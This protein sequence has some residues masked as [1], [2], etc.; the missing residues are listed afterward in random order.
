ML[1][2]FD[3]RHKR[4]NEISDLLHG[5]TKLS[6]KKRKDLGEQWYT[7][8]ELDIREDAKLGE[9]RERTLE[10]LNKETPEVEA[11]VTEEAEGE[12]PVVK[13]EVTE[14]VIV[15][16]KKD[17][18]TSLQEKRNEGYRDIH[19]V[20]MLKDEGFPVRAIKKAMEH[21]VDAFTTLPTSFG[22]IKGGLKEGVKLYDKVLKYIN[23]QSKKVSL[24]EA[25]SNAVEYLKK[26][27]AFKNESDIQQKQM[28]VDITNSLEN[29]FNKEIQDE[30]N[31]LKT[32]IKDQ[33]AGEKTLQKV[34]VDVK[35]FISK[36]MP[37]AEYSKSEVN[38]MLT[39]L[40]NANEKNIIVV[41]KK[42][43][44]L[45]LKKNIDITYGDIEAMLKDG[46]YTSKVSG[47]SKGKGIDSEYF[48]RLQDIKSNM[49]T[50]EDTPDQINEKR[51]KLL[52]K[53]NNKLNQTELTDKDMNE[54]VDIETALFYNEAMLMDDTNVHKFNNLE[55]VRDNLKQLINE[56]KIKR[57]LEL[58]KAHEYYKSLVKTAYEDI[59]GKEL[60]ETKEEKAA[61][62]DESRAFK[63]KQKAKMNRRIGG[64]FRKI[65]AGWKWY[66][67]RQE[68]L[69]G[70]IDT[71]SKSTGE[72]FGGKLQELTTDKI[73]DSNREYKRAV[74]GK[75]WIT[76]EL[77]EKQKEIYGKK[78]K[79]KKQIYRQQ[80]NTGVK[81]ST[82]EDI[83]LSQ[84]QAY[85]LYNQ[86]KD[87]ANHP[88]FETKWGEDHKRIMDEITEKFLKPEVKAWADWQ[89]D[90]FFPSVYERYNEVYKKIYRTNMPWNKFYAGFLSR[91][92]EVK[93]DI[94]LLEEQQKYQTSVGGQSTKLRVKNN[95]AINEE[96]GND[97]LFSY[98]QDM[99][100]FR[101]YAENVRDINKIFQN[102]DV[103]EAIEQTSGKDILTVLDK[104]LEN[105]ANRGLNKSQSAR[106]LNTLMNPFVTSR[107]GLN[108]TVAIKQTTSV[109]AFSSDIGIETWLKYGVN[110]TSEVM[111]GTWK[112]IYDN[113]PYIQDR[114]NRD[115]RDALEAYSGETLFSRTNKINDARI[116]FLD[117]LMYMIKQGDK[118]GIMGGMP[119][120][121]YYKDQY[122]KKNPN[123]TEKQVID[124]AIKR[125]EKDTKNAQQSSDIQ[126]RDTWQQNEHLR[127][128]NLFRTS[129]KQYQRKV[130]SSIRQLLRKIRGSKSKGTL[131][132]NI[133]TL[134]MYHTVLPMV[135]H[136][137]TLGMPGLLADWDDED[138]D[139]L[140]RTLFLGN[141]GSIFIAGDIIQALRDY[142]E[143]KPWASSMRNI[144]ILDYASNLIE[145]QQQYDKARSPEK[146]KKYAQKWWNEA[147]SLSGIPIANIQKLYNNYEKVIT[148]KEKS[149]KKAV[150]RLLGYSEYVINPPLSEKEMKARKRKLGIEEYAGH[151][152]IYDYIQSTKELGKTRE[153]ELEELF[154]TTS[155]DISK[156]EV[157]QRKLKEAKEEGKEFS[158]MLG[159]TG[160][161]WKEYL[162]TL[163]EK[164]ARKE[165]I[166]EIQKG[167]YKKYKKKLTKEEA[168]KIKE[169]TD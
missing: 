51:A 105:I 15:E 124:Y 143:D 56:G 136:W 69:L 94:N 138:E 107:L 113:S 137:T 31:K 86:Y 130:N 153:E 19:I 152:E 81:L 134:I 16:K 73:N 35:N 114:Y 24:R 20:E 76:N 33:V 61:A 118:V 135:F 166:F 3:A 142:S 47:K 59:T 50:S 46:K 5:D 37:V 27:E 100:F 68:A 116:K 58:E 17:L 41:M 43:L 28:L 144:P 154:G 123:A 88:G 38:K 52:E 150:L 87:P 2:E 97:M 132:N 140:L 125:F 110:M 141:L 165:S 14:E 169:G 146:K 160:M 25:Y 42:A 57:K 85:Y 129:P 109:I 119:N 161:N 101:A 75:G 72:M 167:R 98:L 23:N 155:D 108:P 60:P 126:D 45:A 66:W 84:N 162:Q 92:G 62:V 34:K 80:K 77:N 26:Q 71:I 168:K 21:S 30:I 79:R 55:T 39:M 121:L 104:M 49:A 9:I 103:R 53:L 13:E 93:K 63:E 67:N 96:D 11:E 91:E 117:G 115:I 131:K 1:P 120:Y 18:Y 82:G 89:V 139:A 83:T 163:K 8:E 128:L 6:R 65:G 149:K 133:E 157:Y 40:K 151:S 70:I 32:S 122:L 22:S 78:Y 90:V 106:L 12:K 148:G 147:I 7:L 95:N 127:F 74:G 10:A 145:Y 111:E 29:N 156:D 54:I 164:E 112:E 102:K 99:E 159:E 4:M 158:K 48:E 44:E 64:M 36:I